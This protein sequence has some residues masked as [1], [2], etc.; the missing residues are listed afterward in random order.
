MATSIYVN[1]IKEELKKVR[2]C[3]HQMVFIV[4]N[5]RNIAIEQLAL[6][7]EIELINLSLRLSELLLELPV[8]RRN[9]KVGES[10]N[11]LLAEQ[12]DIVILERI[13]LL[14][15]P[16]LQVDPMRLF[17]DISRN[18]VLIID[19]NGKYENGNL[20]YARPGHSEYRS[21]HSLEA[22]VIQAD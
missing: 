19:W 16:E 5:Q 21:Y 12:G 15:L 7:S 13:E 10:V 8:N 4:G 18:T 1:L 6:D 3:R 2:L 9:R 17:E 20:T 11:R 14:F 22:S